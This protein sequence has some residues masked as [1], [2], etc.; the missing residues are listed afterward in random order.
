L[1]ALIDRA[2]PRLRAS[3]SVVFEDIAFEDVLQGGSFETARVALS[4]NG[5]SQPHGAQCA[6]AR[7]CLL[8]WVW[9]LS[10]CMV[11]WPHVLLAQG[12]KMAGECPT[13]QR[14]GSQ[15][16]LQGC[17]RLAHV[18]SMIVGVGRVHIDSRCCSSIVPESSAAPSS[19]TGILTREF[20]RI[21]AEEEPASGDKPL[22]PKPGVKYA[23]NV[24]QATASG[25][26]TSFDV[27]GVHT[28]C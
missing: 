4:T 7:G 17:C 11:V 25:M 16:T 6:R 9:S 14:R 19:T 1:M 28:L 27:A 2:A 18:V 13:S 5:R 21:G 3:Y 8:A 10:R 24:A 12:R 26:R 20:P 23:W 15:R 22:N